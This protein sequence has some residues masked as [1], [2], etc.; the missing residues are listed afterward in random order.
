MAIG[1]KH[2]GEEL[3]GDM[4]PMIDVVFQLLIFFMLSIKFKVLEG[5]L[6]AFLPKDV[7][8]NTS[9]AVPKEKV[10]IKLLV[11]KEGSKVD[12]NDPT[13]PWIKTGPFKYGPDREVKYTV[14]PMSRTKLKDIVPRLKELYALDKESPVSIDPYPGTVYEYVIGVLDE[15]IQVGFTD[16]SFVGDRSAAAKKS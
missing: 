8:V 14:G 11:L 4:T 9:P 3:K 16:V 2:Q 15:V 7:G 13:K 12:P 1:R 10:E 5:K 6:S